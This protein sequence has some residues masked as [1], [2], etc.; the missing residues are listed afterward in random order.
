MTGGGKVLSPVSGNGNATPKAL[1]HQKKV[2]VPT[3][4]V[5]EVTK[6]AGV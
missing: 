6:G 4:Y 5:N 2:N 3:V 1:K